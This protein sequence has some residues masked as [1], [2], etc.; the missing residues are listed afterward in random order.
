MPTVLIVD[1]SE[2]DRLL[3]GRLLETDANIELAYATNG[4]E[5][6]ARVAQSPPDVVVTDLQMPKMDGLDLVTNLRLHHP[7]VAVVLMTAHGNETTAGQAL[8]QG[9]A[10]YVPKNQLA[11]KLLDTVQDIA[12]LALADRTYERLIE[13]SRST[14]FEFDLDNDP[15]LVKPLV[16]LVQQMLAGMS[17][18]DATGQLQLG[19]AL[20]QAVLNAI[21]HGNLELTSNALREARE[22]RTDLIAERRRKTPYCERQV[23]V[24]VHVSRDEVRLVV[25]DEGSGFNVAEIFPS[26][27]VDQVGRRG[28][29]LMRSFMDSVQFNGTGN[30]VT[31]IKRF[32]KPPQDGSPASP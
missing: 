30:E 15:E 32:P 7:R 5:A 22:N 13:C 24:H 16:S 28:L 10:S 29:V 12:A 9:A 2:M 19:V 8:A 17:L 6:L 18:W 1:D 3:A 25:R 26:E 20:E 11:D 4:E 23:F 27:G 14:Q 31:M 21:L